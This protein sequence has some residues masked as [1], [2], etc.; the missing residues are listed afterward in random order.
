MDL[1]RRQLLGNS[2]ALSAL[3]ATPA[4]TRAATPRFEPFPPLPQTPTPGKKGDFAFLT[5]EWRIHHWWLRAPDEWLEFDGEATVFAI[6]DGLVSVEELRIPVRDFH[7]MGLRVLDVEKRVWS[8]HWVN[9]KSGVVT[10]PG[11]LGS[12]ENGAGIF[13]SDDTVEGKPVKYAGVWDQITP[14]S[15][16][17]RQGSSRDGGKTWDQSWIMHWSRVAAQ[18]P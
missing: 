13:V 1:T 18:R 6:L 2:I 10:A 15:C 11:Q 4:W 12:F 8:D 17:W 5:G 7:G 3:T 16:R 14:T 9:A